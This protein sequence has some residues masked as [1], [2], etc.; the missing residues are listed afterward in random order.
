[1]IPAAFL[2]GLTGSLHCV[3]MCG[4]LALQA[5][6]WRIGTVMYHIGRLMAYVLLGLMAGI[7]SRFIALTGWLGWFSV[8]L[9][10]VLI[11]FLLFRQV[12]RWFSIAISNRLFALQ[13]RMAKL[14]HSQ[15]GWAPLA[16]GFLNGWLP[17]GLVYS[18]VVVA[19]VQVSAWHSAGVM[20]AFGAGTVP[21]LLAVK[22]ASA[23]IKT[24]PAMQGFQTIVLAATG[25]LLI[26]RGASLINLFSINHTVLCYPLP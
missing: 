24:L 3:G 8:M 13:Q 9:G 17:C 2:L 10:F 22:W 25:V 14:L 7:V 23:K 6:R 16:L 21:A 12:G 4:V 1:M 11:G 18:A 19:L 15:A 26:W 20:L 5:E